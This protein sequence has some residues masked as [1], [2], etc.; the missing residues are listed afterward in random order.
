MGVALVP[1][2]II[3]RVPPL[4]ALDLVCHFQA[5]AVIVLA[6]TYLVAMYCCDDERERSMVQFDSIK[7]NVAPFVG[8]ES[9]HWFSNRDAI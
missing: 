4:H 9:A 7:K 2:P 3:N 6:V 1:G 8:A 5:L